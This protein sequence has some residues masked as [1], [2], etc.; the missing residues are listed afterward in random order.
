MVVTDLCRQEWYD[1][2]ASKH[3]VLLRRLRPLLGTS[4]CQGLPS[5]QDK[6]GSCSD[7]KLFGEFEERI[8]DPSL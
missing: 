2:Q 3:D 1:L 6:P 4:Q 7:A 5:K 8:A